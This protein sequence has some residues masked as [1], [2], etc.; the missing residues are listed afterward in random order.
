MKRRA[1]VKSSILIGT[2]G[3]KCCNPSVKAKGKASLLSWVS[4]KS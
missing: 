1:G 2:M 4:F 3:R